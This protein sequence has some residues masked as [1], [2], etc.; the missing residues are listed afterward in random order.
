M[1][2]GILKADPIKGLNAFGAQLSF[3]PVQGISAYLNFMD[4]SVSGTIVDLT[5]SFQLSEKFKLGV[6]AAD[7][8]NDGKA[9]Y[10]GVATL[11]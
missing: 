11:P 4:G 10:T 1:M 9:G 8:S 6:N 5:A 2:L 7:F 3:T